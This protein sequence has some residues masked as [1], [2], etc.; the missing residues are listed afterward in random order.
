MTG[1]HRHVEMASDLWMIIAFW[2]AQ[3]ILKENEPICIHAATAQTQPRMIL[4]SPLFI[5]P[6]E[7]AQEFQGLNDHWRNCVER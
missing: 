2:K 4:S 1:K 3:S 7:G 5:R 6:I